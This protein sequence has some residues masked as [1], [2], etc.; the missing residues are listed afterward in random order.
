MKHAP[1]QIRPES[2]ARGTTRYATAP[3]HG[4]CGG[5]TLH[6]LGDCVRCGASAPRLRDW[7]GERSVRRRK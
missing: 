7:E 2:G 6:V 1:S 4:T 5:D 3:C